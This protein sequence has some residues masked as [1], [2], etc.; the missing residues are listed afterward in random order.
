MRQCFLKKT[1]SRIS[2]DSEAYREQ[3]QRIL[4]IKLKNHEIKDSRIPKNKYKSYE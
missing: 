1:C 4:T 3:K 2:P